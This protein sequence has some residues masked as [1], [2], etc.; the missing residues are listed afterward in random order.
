MLKAGSNDALLSHQLEEEP[1][2]CRL[3]MHV[4]C[5]RANP[6]RPL[7]VRL[8]SACLQDQDQNCS[9]QLI[10]LTTH[11]TAEALCNCT[12]AALSLTCK[13][14][15]ASL[16]SVKEAQDHGEATGHSQFEE[17]T[18]PVRQPKLLYNS[19]QSVLRTVSQR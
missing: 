10:V 8:R 6:E 15:N 19:D 9:R 13:Q 12:M 7:L 17:S 4:C 18:E 16:K 1:M 14:C 5:I 3:C 2:L 11:T